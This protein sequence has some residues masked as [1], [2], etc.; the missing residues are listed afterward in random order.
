MVGFAIF[1]GIITF[2]GTLGGL[3][4]LI[5]AFAFKEGEDKRIAALIMGIFVVELSVEES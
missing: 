5:L 2:I 1:L 4:C 3:V